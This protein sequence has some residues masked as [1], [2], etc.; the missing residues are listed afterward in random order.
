VAPL[1]RQ[2]G[3]QAVV[4]GH[5]EAAAGDGQVQPVGAGRSRGLLD[6]MIAA[7]ALAGDL[8]LATR[9][10]PDFADIP[11]LTVVNPWAA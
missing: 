8:A 11:R 6:T 3:P 2:R 5:E 10:T 9:N 7:T 1:W 4:E